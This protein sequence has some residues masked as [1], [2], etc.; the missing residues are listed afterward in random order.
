MAA[1]RTRGLEAVEAGGVAE[2]LDLVNLPVNDGQAHHREGP[3]FLRDDGA[4][5][6]VGEDFVDNGF[7]LRADLRRRR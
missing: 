1:A 5:G 4:R 2:D 6:P 3:G 7:G